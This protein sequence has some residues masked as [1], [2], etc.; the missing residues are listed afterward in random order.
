[1]INS[2]T[3]IRR[4]GGAGLLALALAACGSAETTPTASTGAQ[5]TAAPTAPTMATATMAPTAAATATQAMPDM[6]T[7]THDMSS[8]TTPAAGSGATADAVI[9]TFQFKPEPLEVKAGT[10]VT[11]TNKDAIEHSVTAGTAPSASGA[12]D[13]GFFTQGQTWSFTFNEPGEFAY[14]CMRHNSMVGMV[15]VTK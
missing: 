14:F 3:R 11:W 12:F 1:M 4:L 8:M 7:A 15:K 9:Q 6:A 13:S 2:L 10:T 5:A